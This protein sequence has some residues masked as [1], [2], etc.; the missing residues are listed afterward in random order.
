MQWN[1]VQ[2]F[3]IIGKT[4]NDLESYA[5]IVFSLKKMITKSMFNIIPFGKEGLDK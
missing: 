5:Y 2:S 3:K 4:V 1:I